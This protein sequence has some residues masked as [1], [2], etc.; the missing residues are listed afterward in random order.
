MATTRRI[1]LLGAGG[2]ALRPDRPASA[3]S[4]PAAVRWPLWERSAA[5][6]PAAIPHTDWQGFLD[7]YLVPGHPSGIARVRYGEV[8]ATDREALQRYLRQLAALDPRDYA[9]REQQAFW[10]NLYNA[11]TVE[12]VLAHYP[13]TSIRKIYGGLFDRGPWDEPVTSVAGQALT[14]NDIEHRI[15]RPIFADARIHYAVNCA[16]LGCPNLAAEAYTAANLE[17]LLD[18]GARAYVNHPRGVRFDGER[19][20]LSSLYEWY[21]VDFGGNLAGVRAHLAHFA[22]PALA[23]R[24]RAH[25]GGARYA[26]DWRLNEP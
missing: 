14:L 13:V 8:S 4:G 3:A 5:D 9:P 11:L 22:E 7:R 12:L 23:A 1:L 26:Y 15:L 10:I 24:L 17:A 25:T 19:L 18:T 6:N 2:L 20:A 16:S 21:A